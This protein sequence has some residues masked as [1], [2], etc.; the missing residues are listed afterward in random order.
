M[1]RISF[2][3]LFLC[4]WVVSVC[5]QGTYAL[6][7][8]TAPKAGSTITSVSG[9]KL[10][11]GASGDNNFNTAKANSSVS[12]YKAFTEGNG[13]NPTISSSIPS[14]GT[15]YKFEVSKAGTLE[16]A[17][18]LN[19]DKKFYVI[20]DGK[21]M[22]G[23]N[24]TTKSSKYYGTFS[25][26]VKSGSTYYVYCEASKLGF[27]GFK[28]TTSG[29]GGG[30]S[31]GGES[32]GGE[33]GGG[34]SGGGSSSLSAYD[35]N[36][37]LG[38][39]ASVTGSGD[40]NPVTVTSSSA[41]KSAL[42]GTTAKTIYVK[43]TI[44]ITSP[45]SVEGAKNKTIYGLPGATIYNSKRD[46]SAG[47]LLLSKCSNIIIRNL[48]FKGAGAYDID[49]NDNLSFEGCTNMWVDHC[50]FQDGVDGN[51]DCTKSSDNV[52]VSWCRFR[53]LIAPKSGGSG[54][55]DDHRFSDLWGGGDSEGSDGKLNT[56]FVSCWWDKGCRERMPRVRFGKVH[57][58]NCYWG[59]DVTSYCIGIGYKAQIY[60]QNCVFNGK[61]SNYKF[62]SSSGENDYSIKISGCQGQSD[63]S[64]S[65]KESIFSPSYS[66]TAYSASNVVA[67]VT[68]SSTGAGPT[69][70]I[71]EGGTVTGIDEI[72]SVQRPA[73][74][75]VWYS[76][77][78]RRLSGKPTQ[79]G[80]YI[81]NGRKIAIK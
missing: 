21:A 54:G 67:A 53:Y 66:L 58:V 24:G 69:L 36:K 56:T 23:Y 55:S 76:I 73:P 29:S 64:G 72:I 28:L 41:L 8:G 5:A 39:G 48:T 78:G 63:Y 19:A 46:N 37:P 80:I 12:G 65:K 43:G 22:S 17:V 6:A 71:K 13:S 57:L 33:S 31:G 34:E 51:F 45:I 50:D 11:Y 59:S 1:K 77:D 60:V 9:I 38:W 81:F 70:Q 74:N 27:Y 18:V 20:E 49:S 2:L 7:E 15:F 79:K 40:K 68:D 32:G 16:V 30:E 75:N 14:K 47:G 35:A 61:G 3:A 4:A 44:T 62:A 52:C 25:F 10:T 42:E 26:S